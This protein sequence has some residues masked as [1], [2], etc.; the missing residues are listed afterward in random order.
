MQGREAAHREANNMR[1][2]DLECIEHGADVVACAILRILLAILWN[3][4]RR[5]AAC[6]HGDAAIVAPEVANLLLPRAIVSGEL[7]DEDDRNARASLLVIEL[8]AIVGGQMRHLELQIKKRRRG[9]KARHRSS[10]PS[11]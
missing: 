11:P 5:I 10:P 7:M 2:V 9:P 6:V 8:H 1:P 4:R 3:V